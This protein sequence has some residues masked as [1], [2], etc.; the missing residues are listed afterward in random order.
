MANFYPQLQS[1][2]IAQ[3]PVSRTRA[4]RTISNFLHDGSV[5]LLADP[6]ASTMYWQLNYEGLTDAERNALQAL[7]DACGGR[8]R[9]F[10]FID[11]VGNLFTESGNLVASVWQ[12]S[13]LI[14]L[15]PDQPDAFGGTGATIV[16]N[17]GQAALSLSQMLA[18]PAQYQYCFS[19][20]AK[21][22][23]AGSLTLLRKSGDI[24]DRQSTS[25]D[26][27]WQRLASSGAL[28]AGEESFTAGIELAP[29]QQ[30]EVCG[31][32]LEAQLAPSIYQGTGAQ[33]GVYPNAHWVSDSL[34][35]AADGPG[36]FSTQIEIEAVR[37]G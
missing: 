2:A 24:E 17:T 4:L 33:G 13:A 11:P 21:S 31:L 18:I 22:S 23:A 16:T 14:E 36:L 1:G 8:F 12:H 34:L 6:D 35:F 29:G 15:M 28:N 37:Q 7:F 26:T 27:T 5:V 30:V 20:Y 10:T 9:R 32:Q 19:L 3:Y 25:I